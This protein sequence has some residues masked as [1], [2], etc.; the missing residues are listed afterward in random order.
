MN[1]VNPENMV[2]T[3]IRLVESDEKSHIRL[4]AN[5]GNSI[6]LVCEPDREIDYIRA[7]RKLMPEDKYQIIDLSD[8]LCQFVEQNKSN[9]EEMFNLLQGSLHQIFKTPAGEEGSD[10][11]GLILQAVDS[12]LKADK[13]PV[14]INTGTLYG[15]GIGSIHIVENDLVMRA[16][17]PLIILYPATWVQ[18]MLMFLGKRPASKY[19]CMVLK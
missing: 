12:S 16:K 11:L 1:L 3:T 15:S 5:G 9:L 10:Y 19:R 13:I 17:S 7:I 6:L 4:S 18:D 2:L 8:L 14:L